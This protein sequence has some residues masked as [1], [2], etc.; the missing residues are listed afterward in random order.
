M[1]DTP[2]QTVA[3]INEMFKAV[4]PLL[5]NLAARWSSES[6]YEDINDYAIPLR[7]VVV[8]QHNFELVKMTKRP[9]GFQFSVGTPSVFAVFCT[10][11]N[12]GWKRIK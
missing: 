11:K 9:F 2:Q 7:R 1:S 6:Q 12:I 10:A 4:C 3:Q 8:D 5:D